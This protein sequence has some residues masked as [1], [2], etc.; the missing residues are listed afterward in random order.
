MTWGHAGYGA[1]SSAVQGQL[2]NVQQIQT[3]T[4]AFA[5]ILVRGEFPKFRSVFKSVPRG[6]YLLLLP[7]FPLR[8]GRGK[9]QQVRKK[10]RGTGDLR[11]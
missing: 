2:T 8:G 10:G 4:G 5:A 9:E 7:R 3:S 6:C 1:D 11:G